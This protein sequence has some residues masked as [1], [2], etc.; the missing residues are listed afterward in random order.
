MRTA[1][2]ADGRDLLVVGGESFVPGRETDTPRFLSEIDRWVSDHF[3]PSRRRTWW[4]AQDYR[5]HSRLP[6]AGEIL[7]GQGRIYAATGFNKWGMTNAVAAA[8]SIA[9]D[10]LGGH[11]KWAA[12]L[13]SHKPGLPDLTTGTKVGAAVMA[14]QTADILRDSITW[15][16]SSESDLGEIPEGEGRVLRAKDGLVAKSEVAGRP[17][18]VSAICT[19]LGGTVQWNSAEQSWD[20]PLHGSRFAP[21]GDVLEGPAV[22]PLDQKDP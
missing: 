11:L 16:T 18:A 3:G 17:C 10:I 9:A 15:Q 7:G 13:R 22:R 5:R 6:F 19:H 21:N 12:T 1:K 2:D 4:A 8:L 14:R 20:C